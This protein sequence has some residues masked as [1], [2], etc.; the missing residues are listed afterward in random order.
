MSHRLR[1]KV[2]DLSELL[3]GAFRFRLPWFQRA[4]A[5]QIPH[6]W[7][8]VDSII[9][10]MR[11]PA[12]EQCLHLGTL[13]L[14]QENGSV[15]TA[16]VDG[17]QRMMTLT[18]IFAV[19]RDL[20]Q[21]DELRAR[22]DTFLSEPE[23]V[24]GRRSHRFI[25]NPVLREFC[26]TFVQRPGGTEVMHEGDALELS[27]T[28]SNIIGNRDSLRERLARMTPQERRDIAHF[29]FGGC[30]V[31]LH[32]MDDENAAREMLRTEVETRMDFSEADQARWS[33]LALV[34]PGERRQAS[35]IWDEC[36]SLLDPGD[37]YSM[38]EHL[39]LIATRERLRQT[40]EGE[41]CESYDIEN[42]ALS[43]FETVMLPAARHTARLRSREFGRSMQRKELSVIVERLHWIDRNVWLPAALHW[44]NLHGIG[45]ASTVAFFQQLMRLTW[46]IKI[47][48]LDPSRQKTRL[49]KLLG[50]IDE[51]LP[52]A[53]MPALQIEPQLEREALASLRTQNFCG[54][55]YANPVLRLIET[56]L[57]TDPGPVDRRNVTVE[58]VLPRNPPKRSDWVRMFRGNREIAVHVNRLGNMTFLS[59]EANQLADTKDWE[60][61]R[62]ILALSAFAMTR[63]AADAEKW[64]A[65]N[66][67]SRTECLITTLFKA[68]GVSV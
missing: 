65:A 31:V 1:V 6:V 35:R 68:L 22:L 32:I 28:E 67:K 16:I 4:Y 25:A 54:K 51:N 3:S 5:W 7:R 27:A 38:L 53:E 40:L 42:S 18:I 36:E 49:I 19:L 66:I 2:V 15:D 47:A 48:G 13:T 46:M 58:H 21:D 41:I 57:A 61:K 59:S 63:K 43:F 9:D 17:H 14:A 55:H 20:E 33:I 56:A 39:R 60:A 26:E 52:L 45:H 44:F 62:P 29:M 8:L 34:P 64:D 37:L 24:D 12:E 30:H 23:P 11:R 50:E 10:V